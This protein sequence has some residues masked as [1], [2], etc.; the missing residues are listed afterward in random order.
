MFVDGGGIIRL[1]LDAS[2]LVQ[3]L[4]DQRRR[5]ERLKAEAAAQDE[6]LLSLGALT[7]DA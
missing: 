6:K 3:V 7:R 4:S 2:F 1:S 5:I